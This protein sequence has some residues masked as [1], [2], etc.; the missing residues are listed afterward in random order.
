MTASGWSFYGTVWLGLDFDD[1]TSGQ[2]G[3]VV[4]VSISATTGDNVYIYGDDWSTPLAVIPYTG[5]W[6]TVD[7]DV[8]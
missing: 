7:V 6:M 1:K 3:T 2:S 5:G 8:P 4:G